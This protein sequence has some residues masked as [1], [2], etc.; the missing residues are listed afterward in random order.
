MQ[1]SFSVFFSKPLWA[2]WGFAM[3]AVFKKILQGKK[4]LQGNWHFFFQTK[5][6]LQQWKSLRDVWI[7]ALVW[8]LGVPQEEISCPV[9]PT[10]LSPTG[11]PY[12]WSQISIGHAV[13]RNTRGE[14]KS[15]C[16]VWYF[17][18]L[19]GFSFD[20]Y[21]FFLTHRCHPL[22]ST[23]WMC[24]NVSSLGFAE[25]PRGLTSSFLSCATTIFLFCVTAL[26]HIS[27]FLINDPKCS[28]R[29]ASKLSVTLPSVS[30]APQA[31]LQ[32]CRDLKPWDEFFFGNRA[33]QEHRCSKSTIQLWQVV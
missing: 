11:P 28:C 3:S 32:H 13:A 26:H 9:L 5:K 22:V 20:L 16:L 4:F 29:Q 24:L 1:I 21:H 25:Y 27:T 6:A 15:H 30:F 19:K 8:E 23:G 14:K 10:T 33:R 7:M 2:Q 12:H 18:H 17:A 31:Y